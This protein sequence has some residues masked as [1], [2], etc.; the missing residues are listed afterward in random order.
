M[1]KELKSAAESRN[2]VTADSRKRRLMYGSFSLILIGVVIAAIMLINALLQYLGENVPLT[3][4]MTAN[5]I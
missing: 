1:N 5:K 4:D 3:V 2:N